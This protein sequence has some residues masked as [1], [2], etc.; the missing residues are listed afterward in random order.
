MMQNYCWLLKLQTCVKKRIKCCNPSGTK[1]RA[2]NFLL[3]FVYTD[4]F[5]VCPTLWPKPNE[6][7]RR[8]VCLKCHL[9]WVS[10]RFVWSTAGLH[11]D[12]EPTENGAIPQFLW[13]P[14]YTDAQIEM[15]PYKITGRNEKAKLC[16]HLKWHLI[17][18]WLE[19]A[20]DV[21]VVCRYTT[22]WLASS[23]LS[24]FSLM[25]YFQCTVV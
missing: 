10:R 4:V 8:F 6:D 11:R 7:W 23:A 17:C 9:V 5:V 2:T 12:L 18:I 1:A 21:C 16:C 19:F 14:Y 20:F 15:F 25:L 13:G 24:L 3:L 22:L